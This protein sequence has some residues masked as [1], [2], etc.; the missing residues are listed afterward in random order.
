MQKRC[1]TLLNGTPQFPQNA[2]FFCPGD[3]AGDCAGGID[4]VSNGIGS[5]VGSA[6]GARVSRCSTLDADDRGA[7]GALDTDAYTGSAGAGA[8]AGA[9]TAKGTGPAD[10]LSWCELGS[11]T[12]MGSAGTGS[13]HGGTSEGTAAC[14]EG[15]PRAGGCDGW[16]RND[17]DGPRTE[18][19]LPWD[20][21][22]WRAPG[23]GWRRPGP[24]DGCRSDGDGW[25]SD[26]DGWR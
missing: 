18:A 7:D 5:D 25:R 17:G 4:D 6:G 12:M 9:A 20:G 13:P 10:T 15:G 14:G 24:G 23:D 26:G 19:G 16:R 1:P 22:G 3:G 11:D 21:D 8:G 2:A